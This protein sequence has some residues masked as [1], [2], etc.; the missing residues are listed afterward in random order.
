MG[1][2][3]FQVAQQLLGDRFIEASRSALALPA[4]RPDVLPLQPHGGW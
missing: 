1:N 3:T 4:A 2:E